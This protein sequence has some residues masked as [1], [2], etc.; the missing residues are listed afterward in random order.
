MTGVIARLRQVCAHSLLS[1]FV[2]PLLYDSDYNFTFIVL[3]SPE[4]KTEKDRESA[5]LLS[6][7]NS[8]DYGLVDGFEITRND[9][10]LI[11][12]DLPAKVRAL[13]EIKS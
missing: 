3:A 2:A 4:R 8:D 13:R 5:F 10:P 12:I 6:G 9:N 11:S 7:E 1:H